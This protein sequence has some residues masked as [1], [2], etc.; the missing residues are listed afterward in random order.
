MSANYIG[1]LQSIPWTTTCE[2]NFERDREMS[3]KTARKTH[4]F[5][6]K[7]KNRNDNEEYGTSSAP[8]FSKWSI[9]FRFLQQHTFFSPIPVIR[10]VLFTSLQIT[11]SVYSCA[12][13]KQRGGAVVTLSPLMSYIYIYIYITYRTANLQKLYFIYLV[14]KISVLNI[15]NMLHILRSFLFNMQFVS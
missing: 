6:D 13:V 5:F 3:E 4:I 14:K 10:S 8:S 2:V 11:F 1:I 9:F 15:L 7:K 12:L